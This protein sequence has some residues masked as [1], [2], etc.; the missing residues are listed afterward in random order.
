[1]L[2][3]LNSSPVKIFYKLY[4]NIFYGYLKDWIGDK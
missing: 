4:N 3:I 1:L 2:E